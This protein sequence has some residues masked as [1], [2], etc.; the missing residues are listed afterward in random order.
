MKQTIIVLL[1]AGLSCFVQGQLPR[2]YDATAYHEKYGV[3]NEDKEYTS[4]LAFTPTTAI[5]SYAAYSFKKRCPKAANAIWYRTNDDWWLVSYIDNGAARAMS[6]SSDGGSYP[7]SLPL[8]QNAV[9]ADVVSAVMERFSAVYDI[10]AV[11]TSETQR[12]YTVR[13]ME[14]DG[15]LKSMKVGEDGKSIVKQ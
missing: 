4:T 6:Y 11:I 8:L 3:A 14:K 12:N 7:V 15:T 10:R 2:I 13:T 9:P 5:P 1:L